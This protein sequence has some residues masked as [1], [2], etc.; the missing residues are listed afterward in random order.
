MDV[1]KDAEEHNR[2]L[3]HNVRPGAE[4]AII[5]EK[6]QEDAEDGFASQPMTWEE[7]QQTTGGTYPRAAHAALRRSPVIW[8]KEDH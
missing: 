6:S 2:L 1:F 4:D 8:Q 3:M 7:L 5:L